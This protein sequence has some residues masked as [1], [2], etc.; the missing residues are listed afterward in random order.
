MGFH[1]W[2]ILKPAKLIHGRKKIKIVFASGERGPRELPGVIDMFCVLIGVLLPQCVHLC[3]EQSA[4]K[5][6]AFHWM[7]MLR[8]RKW[9]NTELQLKIQMLYLGTVHWCLQFPL[10]GS[11]EGEWINRWS[12]GREDNVVMKALILSES[13]ST[14]GSTILQKCLNTFMFLMKKKKLVLLSQ[15][16]AYHK[17]VPLY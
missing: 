17:S 15:I 2:E 10:K 6:C 8:Q 9:T 3:E 12:E 5:I 1:L 7:Q 4:L 14:R 11:T 16:Q 13:D